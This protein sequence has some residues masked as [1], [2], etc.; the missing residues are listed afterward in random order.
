MNLIEFINTYLEKLYEEY[1]ELRKNSPDKEIKKI[2]IY[3]KEIDD[4]LQNLE[5]NISNLRYLDTSDLEKIITNN[6]ESN[7]S[8]EISSFI[9][10]FKD[11]KLV[12][13]AIYDEKLPIELTAK[14]ESFINNFIT[15]L[16]KMKKRELANISQ[17]QVQSIENNQRI[18]IIEDKIL[19]LEILKDQ[20]INPSDENILDI[21]SFHSFMNI[22]NSHLINIDQKKK[23]LIA[24]KKYND[25]RKNNIPK[26]NTAISIEDVKKCFAEFITREDFFTLLDKKE[27]KD[28]IIFNADLANIR[29]ILT[30]LASEDLNTKKKN[31]IGRFSNSALL[32]I[33][34]YG[35]KN[36]I[37]Q[38][39]ETII[40]NKDERNILFDIPSVWIR[41][42]EKEII[43]RRR[44]QKSSSEI[45]KK[46]PKKQNLL[47]TQAHKNSYEEILKNEKFLTNKG[48]KVSLDDEKNISALVN[49]PNYLLKENYEILK[50]YGVFDACEPKDFAVST[51]FFS[52]LAEKCDRLIELGLFHPLNKTNHLHPNYFPNHPSIA[53]WLNDN[54]SMVLYYQK[55][56]NS[57]DDYYDL[58]ASERK[59]GHLSLQVRNSDMVQSLNDPELREKFKN[60]FFISQKESKYIPNYQIYENIILENNTIEYDEAILNLPEIQLL[61]KYCRVDNNDYIY[62]FG[63]KIISRLKVLRNYSCL[64]KSGTNLDNDSLIYAIT[65]ETYLDEETFALIAKIISYDY[66]GESTN[67]LPKE[68]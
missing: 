43:Y 34:L 2:D 33:C 53:N 8:F 66:K 59:N 41:N 29:E 18:T 51:F 22:V 28:E 10:D 56:A 5:Q 38:R 48:F 67:E 35:N 64:K 60:E 32:T 23:A 1:D 30:Y 12:L 14:Q 54:I 16:K 17:M 13:K 31:I 50:K 26:I 49:T 7:I 45:P 46:V 62:K 52:Q 39:Y 9:K 65:R 25:D 21:N 6:E 15:I 44:P 55:Q 40:K 24:F 20:I 57:E 42:M 36:F 4:L 63:D 47:V 61:E 68:I 11:T 19:D 37:K 58:I 27:V 3:I